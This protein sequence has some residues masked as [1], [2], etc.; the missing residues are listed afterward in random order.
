MVYRTLEE[1]DVVLVLLTLGHCHSGTCTARTYKLHNGLPMKP[2][3][4]KDC[5]GPEAQS[6]GGR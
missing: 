5:V 4:A 3:F 1:L 2:F 6:C